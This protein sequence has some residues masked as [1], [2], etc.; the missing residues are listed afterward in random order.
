[1]PIRI[2]FGDQFDL[3]GT[4]PFFDVFLALDGMVDVPMDLKID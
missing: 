2:E 1:M 4:I 3:P